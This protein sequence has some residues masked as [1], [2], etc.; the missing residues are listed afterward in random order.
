M[1]GCM[2][3]LVHE[4]LS[5]LF[6]LGVCMDV[7]VIKTGGGWKEELQGCKYCTP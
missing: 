2:S 5:F 4:W 1:S 7:Y 6:V 3:G